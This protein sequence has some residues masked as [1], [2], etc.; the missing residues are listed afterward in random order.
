MLTG[1]GIWSGGQGRLSLPLDFC[2]FFVFVFE[3]VPLI[4]AISD[5]IIWENFCSLNR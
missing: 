4:F 5:Q 3:G 1:G 2:F